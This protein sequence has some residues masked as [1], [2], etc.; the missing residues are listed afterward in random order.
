[1]RKVA[2]CF[3]GLTRSLKYTLDS[4]K[5]K[6]LNELEKAG[7]EYHIFLHTYQIDESYTNT[8]SG[9]HNQILDNE[10]YKLLKPKDYIIENQKEVR[11]KLNLQQ[12]RT[13][14]D[15]WS[16]NFETADNFI[17]AL[18][19]KFQVT[20]LVKK[21]GII[22]DN[23]MYCRPDVK[24]LTKFDINW[25]NITQES[26]IFHTPS[27]HKW[28]GG[29]NDRFCLSNYKNSI[30]YGESFSLLLEYSKNIN[31]HSE[32]FLKN[33]MKTHNLLNVDVLFNFNRI[34]CNGR[35]ENDCKK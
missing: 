8:R 28:R 23:I 21:S 27:F 5:E 10:E 16:N 24:Y 22:Y 20:Q 1:M 19:S 9:E 13:H 34:R 14:G 15:P 35:E 18:Y 33:Y 26:N 11:S 29:L 2:I 6:I 4:I 30:I 3:W 31:I 12:Y 32:T 25:L 17:S 7:I